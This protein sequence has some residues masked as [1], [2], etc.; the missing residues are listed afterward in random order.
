[1]VLAAQVGFLVHLV[2]LLRPRLGESGAAYA[3][4]AAAMAA[5]LGRIGLGLIIDRLDQRRVSAASFASQA[6]GLGLIVMFPANPEVLYAACCLFGLSVGNVITLP[7]LIIQREFAA[8]SFGLMVG[9]S[10]GIGQVT[11]AF[12]PAL[13]GLIRDLA[14]DYAPALVVCI[15]LELAAAAIVISYRPASAK[16]PRMS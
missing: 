11:F 9:L 7:S 10:A 12:G 8:R 1:L 13:L 4:A 14:G 5:M 6:I 2:A 15:A 16:S 3:V